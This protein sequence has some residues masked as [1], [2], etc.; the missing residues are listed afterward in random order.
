MLSVLTEA[1]F[2]LDVV[3]PREPLGISDMEK[4]ITRAKFKELLTEKGFVIKPSGK[5]TL[6]PMADSRPAL[7]SAEEAV[8]DFNDGFDYQNIKNEN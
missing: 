3:A 2:A 7:G 5:P 6:V 4:A 8:Q 1:G